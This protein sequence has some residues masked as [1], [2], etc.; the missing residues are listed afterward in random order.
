MMSQ[1]TLLAATVTA[2]LLE[3]AVGLAEGLPLAQGLP[4]AEGLPLAH[5]LALAEGLAPSAVSSIVVACEP[6]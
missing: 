2:G 3:V 1:F 4:L 6:P 5:G